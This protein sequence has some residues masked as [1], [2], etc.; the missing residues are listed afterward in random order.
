MA[1]SGSATSPLP[2]AP[3]EWQVQ[4]DALQGRADAELAGHTSDERLR[5]RLRGDDR[6]IDLSVRSIRLRIPRNY[7]FSRPS[8]QGGKQEIVTIEVTYPDLKPFSEATRDCFEHKMT[9]ELQQIGLTRRINL[10]SEEWFRNSHRFFKNK[11]EV[12]GY[13]KYDI[14]KTE[15]EVFAKFTPDNRFLTFT[16]APPTICYRYMPFGDDLTIYYVFRYEEIPNE[17]IRDAAL[18]GLVQSF[19][20]SRHP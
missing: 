12:M 15:N 8:W 18:R 13:E 11:Q 2:P 1:D 20:V 5:E 17:E 4:Q 9:C 19:V 7:L 3:T 16:C 10:G 14:G 6:L